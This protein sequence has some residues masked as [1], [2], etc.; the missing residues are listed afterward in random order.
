[1]GANKVKAKYNKLSDRGGMHHNIGW[2][3]REERQERVAK[4]IREK[5]A[6]GE[7][8]ERDAVC[9]VLNILLYYLI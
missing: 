4:I 9:V 7:K 1:M 3:N 8:H 5:K 2:L 6:D